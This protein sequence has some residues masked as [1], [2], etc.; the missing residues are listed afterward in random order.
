M[1]PIPKKVFLVMKDTLCSENK[2][3]PFA[4]DGTQKYR[5]EKFLIF[6]WKGRGAQIPMSDAT[7]RR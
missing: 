1:T 3:N 6:I 7:M 2:I 4:T 5:F